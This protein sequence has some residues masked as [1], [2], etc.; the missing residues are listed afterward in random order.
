MPDVSTPE[1]MPEESTP[2]KVPDESTPEKVPDESTPEKVPDE[3][4]P[5]KVP[6]ESTPEKVPD[7]TTVEIDLT[8]CGARKAEFVLVQDLSS[9]FGDDIE[10]LNNVAPELFGELAREFPGSRFGLASFR[11]KGDERKFRLCSM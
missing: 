6:D 4:T 1:K 10:V 5:E 2:E 11:D 8:P 3:S 9:S 7:E